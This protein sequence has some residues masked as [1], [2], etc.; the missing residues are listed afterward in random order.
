MEFPKLF[1]LQQSFEGPELSDV[2]GEVHRQLNEISLSE[3]ISAGESVAITV[4][5]RGIANIPVIVRAIADFLKNIQAKPFI[6]PAM[7]SHGGATV[8]GQVQVLESLGVTAESCGCPIRASMETVVVCQSEQG[9]DVHFDRHAYEADHVLVCGRVKLHTD[10]LGEIQSG[11]MKMMLIGLGKQKGASTY[12]RA[13]Q[14]F[15]F[16]QIIRS[17]SETVIN[18]C[19]IVAGLAIVENGFEQTALIE[20]VRP[21]EIVTREPELL[22]LSSQWM[23]RLPFEQVDVLII[24]EIGKNISGTGMDTNVVGRKINE[25]AAAPDEYPKVKRIIVRGLTEATHGNACGIGVADFTTQNVVD[26]MDYPATRVNCVTSGRMGGGYIPMCFA[27]DRQALEAA[28]QTI[29]LIPPEQVRLLR[30]RNT[31]QLETLQCSQAYLDEAQ[32]RSD[33]TVV[34]D[35]YEMPF[36]PSDRLM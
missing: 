10:F 22:R 35:L 7:G 6:V 5:S 3:K 13:F 16:D 26:E 8:E 20:A 9:F 30:I 17:V 23:A 21:E 33:L 31:L 28:F 14:E 15:S 2:A 34:G 11:L 27:T 1:R 19:Q 36:E 12:H 24:D 4:G 25:N 32:G 29:G 18:H